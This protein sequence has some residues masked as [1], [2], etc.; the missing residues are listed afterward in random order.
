MFEILAHIDF[1]MYINQ[2]HFVHVRCNVRIFY[3][4][5][6]MKRLPPPIDKSNLSPKT[7]E[8][9]TVARAAIAEM[10]GIASTI[11]NQG[12]LLETLVM[13]EAKGS[14]E[15]E[16]IITTMEEIYRPESDRTPEAK[17][18]RRYVEAME[19]GMEMIEQGFIS[20]NMM[21]RIQQVLRN[22][23]EGV[24]RLPGTVLKNETTGEVVHRPPQD[25]REIMDLLGNLEAYLN[26][27]IEHDVDPL[28]KMAISH[29]QFEAI[30]PFHDGNG[31]TGR[32]IN[33]LYLVQEGILDLPILC[34]S[35]YIN[36]NKPKYYA[37]LRQVDQE[38]NGEDWILFML[39]AACY[40]AQETIDSIQ[41]I[42]DAM[43]HFKEEIRRKLPTDY[44][45]DLINHLFLWPYTT[46]TALAR[47]FGIDRRTAD[48]IL[49]D[50]KGLGLLQV[51]KIGRNKYYINRQLLSIFDQAS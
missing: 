33:L 49:G 19:A 24:R 10:K 6:Y 18:V 25:H 42:K 11:P 22:T 21:V 1:N 46:Q 50:L 13:Q 17:E 47:E 7:W 8:A 40:T 28:I 35:R 26:G 41:R 43:S 51:K 3:Q 4:K 44:S 38:E 2:Q 20:K 30:H 9:L 32:I 34:M 16:N 36:R 48:R 29:Y 5:M 12:V 15:I 27:I 31:R 14:S 39:Y 45:Q 23:S 37:L